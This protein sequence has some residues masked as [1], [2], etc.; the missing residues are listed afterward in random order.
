MKQIL[1]IQGGGEDG[2]EA[3]KS[4]AASLQKEMGRDYHIIYPE[5]K[6]DESAPDFGW[7]QQIGEELSKTKHGIFLAGHSLGASMILK[8]LSENPLNSNIK[9]VF[10]I[11]TPFWRGNEDWKQG[12][13]LKE[14]F[15]GKLPEQVPFFFYHSK[16][17]EEVPF[18][19]LNLYR[20]KIP[21]AFFRETETGG[22][23]LN[24]NL[25]IVSEDIRSLSHS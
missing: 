3:G 11:A 5:L 25:S 22:H 18:S 14:D 10:L 23:Q 12:L 20:Q 1:L 13:K 7:V 17:D 24:G 15:A 16:D 2:Y 9:G 19:H 6:S 21:H 8:Y 4:L